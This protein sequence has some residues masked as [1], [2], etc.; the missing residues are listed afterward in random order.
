VNT[1]LKDGQMTAG[2][3]PIVRPKREVEVRIGARL[4]SARQARRLTIEKVADATGLNKGF[5]SRLER[6]EVSASVASLV[7]VCDVLG[8]RVGELFDSPTTSF[9][10]KGTGG[11]INFGGDNVHEMLLTPGNQ[12]QLQVI[13]SLME[14]GASGGEGLYTLNVNIEF[15]YVVAGAVDVQFGDEVVRVSAGDALT[16]PGR[17]PHT[18]RNASKEEGCEALWVLA[19][20]P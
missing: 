1:D 10:K 8:I 7:A 14:P 4:R 16:L 15:L 19:P 20:A 11:P 5:V 6:D 17:E 13:H 12:G 9:V 2:E 3:R 18:W